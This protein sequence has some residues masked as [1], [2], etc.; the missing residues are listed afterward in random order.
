MPVEISDHRSTAETEA[1]D[2]Q[3]QLSLPL[4]EE[5]IFRYQAMD[6]ILA[7]LVYNYNKE[8][9]HTEL[10][11]QTGHGGE[12]VKRALDLLRSLDLIKEREEGRKKLVRINPGKIDVPKDPIFRIPQEEFREPVRT[13]L[14]DLRNVLD[15][16]LLG[17]IL[18]GSVARGEADR[19]SD[20][21]IL[22]VVEDN[23]PAARRKINSIKSRI[24]EEK[25]NGERYEFQILV[26]SVRSAKNR[27]EGVRDIILDGV[28]LYSKPRFKELIDEVL[29]D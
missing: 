4:P 16:K 14:S 15:E 26:E 22:A 24:E 1:E 10:R 27:S 12:T 13:F 20:I 21:D 7:L 5:R 23:P 11:E 6:D 17:V 2:V 29:E 9:S 19:R 3:I 25:F 8:F 18:F 28:V